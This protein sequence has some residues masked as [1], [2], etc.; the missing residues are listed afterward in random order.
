MTTSDA[1]GRIVVEVHPIGPTE[2]TSRSL[3]GK[4]GS[5]MELRITSI[6]DCSTCSKAIPA[7]ACSCCGD[8]YLARL[9]IA[10]AH[11]VLLCMACLA[12]RTTRKKCCHAAP[13]GDALTR[14]VGLMESGAMD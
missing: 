7:V 12:A 8:G 4:D 1:K 13:S 9:A 5:R 6:A 11:G 14:L 3:S 10:H 2:A